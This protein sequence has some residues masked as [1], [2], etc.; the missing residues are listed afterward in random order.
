ML[1][2]FRV[3]TGDQPPERPEKPKAVGQLWGFDGHSYVFL[4]PKGTTYWCQDREIQ[5]DRE[6]AFEYLIEPKDIVSY[7]APSKDYIMKQGEARSPRT[8]FQV[9]DWRT[10]KEARHESGSKIGSGTARKKS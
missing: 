7:W 4:V 9:V 5:D 2:S 3:C 8:K 10:S 6:V 1:F